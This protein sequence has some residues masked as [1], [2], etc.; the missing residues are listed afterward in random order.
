MALLINT[1]APGA[2][3]SKSQ[4]KPANANQG[5]PSS[6][7]AEISATLAGFDPFV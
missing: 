2:K 1:F 6:A 5:R 3:A 4:Q 7:H